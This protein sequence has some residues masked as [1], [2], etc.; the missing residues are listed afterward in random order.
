MQRLHG[1]TRE[2][3]AMKSR[4]NERAPERAR[5]GRRSGQ[6]LVEFVMASAVLM[7]LALGI[8]EFSRHYYARMTVRHHVGEAARLAATGRHLTDP[9]TGEEMTRAESVVYFI[10]SR[11][12]SAPVVL[13]SVELDPADGGQP[14]DIVSIRALY[15]FRFMASPLVRSFAPATALFTVAAV[16]KNEPRF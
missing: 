13:E 5:D 10:E 6:A 8:V 7:L 1:A 15:R 12:G 9:E 16:V 3:T 11:A 2:M 4:G 14:G